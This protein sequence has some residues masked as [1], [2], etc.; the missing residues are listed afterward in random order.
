MGKKGKMMEVYVFAASANRA[1]HEEQ[2]HN[3]N[4]Y[5]CSISQDGLKKVK[6]R[7]QR[8]V[9]CKEIDARETRSRTR[10]PTAEFHA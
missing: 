4:G 1:R 8:N 7:L 9:R 2:K 6:H 10:M 5:T 3:E